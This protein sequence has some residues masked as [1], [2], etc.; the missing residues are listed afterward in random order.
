MFGYSICE[1]SVKTINREG[2]VK[3]LNGLLKCL[4]E[5]KPQPDLSSSTPLYQI[6]SQ[7]KPETDYKGDQK[8]VTIAAA[9]IIAKVY[10]DNLM[11]K[12]HEKIVG[13]AST[14]TRVT[15]RRYIRRP[16]KSTAFQR[17]TAEFVPKN[18]TGRRQHLEGV[19]FHASPVD[20]HG[21]PL[22]P[23]CS[24]LKGEILTAN[25]NNSQNHEQDPKSLNL[26]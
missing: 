26:T 20:F 2:I 4:K 14:Y 23:T 13:T 19:D 17:H 1:T 15:E 5:I 24:H 3:A 10:R 9:S 25:K 12:L 22:G 16:L 6:L 8:S 21:N 11:V 18:L 7:E